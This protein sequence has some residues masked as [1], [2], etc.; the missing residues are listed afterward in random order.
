VSEESRHADTR[1]VSSAVFRRP[2]LREL[3]AGAGRAT[4]YLLPLDSDPLD[5]ALLKDGRRF[6]IAGRRLQSKP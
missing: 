2:C 5:L 1:R 6:E 3:S 4:L